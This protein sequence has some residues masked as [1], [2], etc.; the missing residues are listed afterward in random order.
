MKPLTHLI[1]LLLLT[2]LS[3]PVLSGG[4]ASYWPLHDG[5]ATYFRY[6]KK[7]LNIHVSVSDYDEFEISAITSKD[8]GYEYHRITPDGVFLTKVSIGWTDIWFD[9]DVRL[10]NDQVL[11]NGGVL[12]TKTE[13][14]QRYAG[15][16]PA[17]FKIRVKKAGTVKVPAG[18]FTDC[19]SITAT[20]TATLPN[21]QRVSVKA[22]TAILAPGVG[23]I[24]KLVAPGKWA[25][26]VSGTVG[27]QDV[28]TLAAQ[29]PRP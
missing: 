23:I 18:V 26:L 25:V 29:R 8:S 22:L 15:T 10:M 27:G 1:V 13:V 17:K 19:R 3:G 24:K 9:P 20:E 12:T 21:G 5:D 16:Y 28:T 6:G 7:S 2:C 14:T 11:D 4:V